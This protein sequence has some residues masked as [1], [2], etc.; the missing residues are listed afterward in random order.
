MTTKLLVSLTGLALCVNVGSAFTVN[1][2]ANSPTSG[3]YRLPND[4]PLNQDFELQW[5]VFDLEQFNSLSDAEKIDFAI[6]SGLLAGNQTIK[7]E[8][9]GT[10]IQTGFQIPIAQL[11]G[12]GASGDQLYT[13]VYN[14][15]DSSQFGL[16]TST[17]GFWR[18]PN[19]DAGSSILTNS[20]FP[21]SGSALIPG[22]AI[23]GTNGILAVPE[24]S[25]YAL[26]AGGLVLGLVAYRR[27][28]VA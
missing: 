27:R 13:L 11:A 25:T 18:V 16:F 5:G 12:G 1:I 2:F 10:L 19:D 23:D 9:D 14:T 20:V 15:V 8:N 24:P 22:S 3:F 21:S 17:D 7:F 4:Q 6:V 26:I 28:C